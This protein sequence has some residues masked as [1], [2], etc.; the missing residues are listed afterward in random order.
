[1]NFW[2]KFPPWT[3]VCHV[4]YDWNQSWNCH[5]HCCCD[6][7]HEKPKFPNHHFDATRFC[8]AIHWSGFHVLQTMTHDQWR[9]ANCQWPRWYVEERHRPRSARPAPPRTRRP[10]S[11]GARTKWVPWWFSRRWR[12]WRAR[13]AKKK[14]TARLVAGRTIPKTTVGRGRRERRAIHWGESV[15]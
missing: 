5:C 14:A 4:L 13:K 3:V 8:T 9:S 6:S 7:K 2:T 12:W 10:R 11:S 1:M 15:D